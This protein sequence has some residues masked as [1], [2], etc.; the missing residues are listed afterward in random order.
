MP[1]GQL[2][3]LRHVFRSEQPNPLLQTHVERELPHAAA[4]EWMESYD[5]L[6][7]SVEL[8]T[9]CVR[10][11]RVF[12]SWAPLREALVSS[13][14]P[15][16][17]VLWAGSWLFLALG[18]YEVR[19]GLAL[20][21]M[22]GRGDRCR[23]PSA[24]RLDTPV[25]PC[26]VGCASVRRGVRG[27]RSP[28]EPRLPFFFFVAFFFSR[29]LCSAWALMLSSIGQES[30]PDNLRAVMEDAIEV[31]RARTAFHGITVFPPLDYVLFFAQKVRVQ[32]KM[33]DHLTL[34]LSRAA[35]LRD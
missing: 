26:G 29:P 27:A 9:S 4:V 32:V 23:Y 15:S 24:S 3:D 2:W 17:N 1:H 14:A 16:F 12:A 7:A 8:H 10:L 18:V 33:S 31:M 20:L 35:I 30:E 22:R 21:W 5:A 6:C 11:V 28:R 34:P 19:H 25:R 13:L